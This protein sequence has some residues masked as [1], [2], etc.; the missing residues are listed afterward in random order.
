[1]KRLKPNEI[2]RIDDQHHPRGYR[3]WV[4]PQELARRRQELIDAPGP[5]LCYVHKGQI[6]GEP[7]LEHIIPKGSG[8]STHDDHRENLALSCWGCNADKGSR[9]I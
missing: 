1:V 9:R 3:E 6:I 4:G 8:G 2:R 5:K 7:T